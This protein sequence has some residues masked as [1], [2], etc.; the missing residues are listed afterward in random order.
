MKI[1]IIVPTYNEREN[2]GPLIE[3]LEKIIS[4]QTNHSINILVVDDNSPDKTQDVINNKM[5]KF[6][7]LSMITGNKEG[8]GKALLRG[9]EHA[10]YKWGSDYFIQMDADFSHDPKVIP[11]MIKKAENQG[12][13]FIVGARYIP[14]GSIPN[15]WGIH[16]KILS[17]YGNYFIRLV[18]NHKKV[19]DWTTG[20]RMIKSNIFE[21]VKHELTDFSGYTY[22]ASF[23]HKAVHQKAK[24]G[25]VP[26]NFIDRKYGRSKMTG[27][28]FK[29]MLKYIVSS[30]IYE[31]ISPNFLKVCIVGVVGFIINTIG[32]EVFVG[33]G[34]H[35]SI[36]A[37]IGA[38]VAIFS[39]F[40]LNNFWSFKERKLQRKNVPAK[41]IQFNLMSFGSVVIQ[42]GTIF[43][44]TH[45]F[46]FYTYRIFYVI[47]VLLGLIWNYTVYSKV[48]WKK[49]ES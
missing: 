13:D 42:A 8:L 49:N 24:I 26:I 9:M 29:N 17:V 1:T 43:I 45:L 23:L 39:N 34:L 37:A 30:R 22:Q 11:M 25:E 6:K 21:K 5:T 46:G 44:G 12:Y 3:E 33:L 31:F 36:A 7:N 19:H 18:L 2:I 40:T 10:S 27:E 41:F 16:R 4:N 32:L 14:G 15:N 48:I 28:Y 38:E 47:G 20:Y 35:P